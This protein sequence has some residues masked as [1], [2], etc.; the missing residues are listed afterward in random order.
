MLNASAATIPK[1]KVGNV[2]RN[3]ATRLARSSYNLVQDW[4]ALSNTKGFGVTFLLVGSWDMTTNRLSDR[5]IPFNSVSKD[6]V[7]ASLCIG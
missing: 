7:N 3:A 6:P 5:K 4:Y 2:D 1:C